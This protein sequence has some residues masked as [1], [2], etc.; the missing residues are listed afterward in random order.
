MVETL[1]LNQSLRSAELQD[2]D[3]ICFQR[4]DEKKKDEKDVL[5]ERFGFSAFGREEEIET[6]LT[7][8]N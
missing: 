5:K 3:I 2:G 7:Y 4:I 1:E 8:V 6:M